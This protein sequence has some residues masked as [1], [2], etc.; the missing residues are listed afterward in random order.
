M[1]KDDAS[2]QVFG[3]SKH[4]GDAAPAGSDPS[5]RIASQHARLTSAA[6]HMKQQSSGKRKNPTAYSTGNALA[7]QRLKIKGGVNG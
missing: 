7:H 3:G 6:V 5:H 2:Q 4:A 1:T